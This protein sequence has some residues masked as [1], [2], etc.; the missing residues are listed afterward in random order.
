MPLYSACG[1]QHDVRDK[2]ASVAGCLRNHTARGAL[3]M[4]RTR[5][6]VFTRERT[7]LINMLRL[8]TLNTLAPPLRT[9]RD[10]DSTDQTV[11]VGY[12]PSLGRKGQRD[13]H[14]AE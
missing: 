7:L 4:N 6:T 9:N 1:R 13:R 10:Q 12:V 8:L 11:Q 5:S 2:C 14:P 3:P